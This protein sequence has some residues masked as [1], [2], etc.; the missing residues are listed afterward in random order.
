MAAGTLDALEEEAAVFLEMTVATL[1]V[2]DAVVGPIDDELA[3]S[4]SDDGSA[5][6][7]DGEVSEAE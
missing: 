3:D 1:Q 7:N 6:E 2:G 4:D 5:T